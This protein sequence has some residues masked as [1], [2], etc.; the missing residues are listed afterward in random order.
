V[1]L[2]DNVARLALARTKVAV[3]ERAARSRG[4]EIKE[5]EET[6]TIWE[7]VAHNL[8][9]RYGKAPAHS[10]AELAILK[11]LYPDRIRFW[12]AMR[13]STVI[14]AIV[15]F[16][17]TQRAAHTFYIAHDRT[18]AGVNPMPLLVSEICANLAARGF[19][20]L[21]FGISTRGDLV[22]WGILEF[23]EFMGGRGV[24]R[25]EWEF[26]DLTTFRPYDW[27]ATD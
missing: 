2:G 22:K 19:D 26:S 21:N 20:W 6:D 23:K 10:A 3:D 17:V 8:K 11:Q 18:P 15:V 7:L 27:N 1:R 16:E 5:S 24:C 14:A 4:V 25:E 9:Q 12:C 13:D